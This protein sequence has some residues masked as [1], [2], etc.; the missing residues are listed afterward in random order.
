MLSNNRMMLSTNIESIKE[1]F[2]KKIT[3]VDKKLTI[4]IDKNDELEEYIIDKFNNS[5]LDLKI[6]DFTYNDATQAA[7][8]YKQDLGNEINGSRGYYL[9]Y[10][11]VLYDTV[12]FSINNDSYNPAGIYNYRFCHVET[13]K[14]DTLTVT[15]DYS[16]MNNNLSDIVWKGIAFDTTNQKIYLYAKDYDYNYG[17]PVNKYI[18]YSYDYGSDAIGNTILDISSKKTASRTVR[19]GVEDQWTC[20]GS[21]CISSGGTSSSASSYYTELKN[22]YNNTTTTKLT[23]PT[24]PLTQAEIDY[25]GEKSQ[26]FYNVVTDNNCQLSY[27]DINIE[28]Q[29][30]KWT[31]EGGYTG[32]VSILKVKKPDFASKIWYIPSIIWYRQEYEYKKVGISALSEP[33]VED[34]IEEYV[35]FVK[36]NEKTKDIYDT[37]RFLEGLNEDIKSTYDD[38]YYNNIYLYGNECVNSKFNEIYGD[39]S[40]YTYTD[41]SSFAD[42]K[43]IIDNVYNKIFS[44]S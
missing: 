28:D 16:T 44:A 19:T 6:R 38:S 22:G 1:S 18:Y 40:L 5:N 7:D 32:F 30:I 10:I 29:N 34:D 25:I 39:S 23:K 35:V 33:T 27:D 15:K 3:K 31:K 42:E 41:Y 43:A 26:T 20:L 21:S 13:N 2:D 37:C 17:N 36:N 14:C 4:Y 11:G 12:I 9:R 24:N 8:A